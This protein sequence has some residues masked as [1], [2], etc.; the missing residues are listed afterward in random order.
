MIEFLVGLLVIV[1]I[2]VLSLL[3]TLFFPLLLLMGI[4]L[5]FF[6]G[7]FICLFVVWLIG[8]TTLLIIEALRKK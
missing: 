1:M 8:K 3:G 5:R 6:V 4:F 7:I 2:G